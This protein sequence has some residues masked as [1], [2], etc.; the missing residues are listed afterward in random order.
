MICMPR[1][2]AHV[3]DSPHAPV[4]ALPAVPTAVWVSDKCA[5]VEV[6]DAPPARAR[7]GS[8]RCECGVGLADAAALFYPEG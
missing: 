3:P 7:E 2:K 8:C 6:I 4:N 1:R 5:C